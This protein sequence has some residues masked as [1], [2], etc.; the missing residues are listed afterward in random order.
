MTQL[1]A[2]VVT[3][4]VGSTEL[5]TRLGEDR[6]DDLR[7]AHDQVLS[8]A[9]IANGG[10]VVKG[11]GDGI[12]ARF[13]GAADA[14]TAAVAMQQAAART[15]LGHSEERLHIRIG[16]AVGDISLEEGDVFGT[17]VIE[18]SRLCS[19]AEGGQI[20]VADLVRV[21]T[22]GR[23]EHTFTPLGP[24]PLKGLAAPVDVCEVGWEALKSGLPNF[25]LPA[26]LTGSDPFGFAGRVAAR[27]QLAAR[28]KA[29]CV[30][31]RQIVLVAGEPGIGKTRL[32]SELARDVADDG[33]VVTLGRCFEDV[34]AA[35]APFGEALAHLVRHV[36]TALLEAHVSDVG[37]DLVRVVP[38]LARRVSLPPLTKADAE[39]ERM[40]LFDAV[41]DLLARVSEEAPVLL[42][43]DDL[44]W[45]DPSTVEMLLWLAR[46]SRPMRL[47]VVGTY[48]DTD[49]TRTHAFGGALTELRRTRGTER[50]ALTGLD[51]H[52][53]GAFLER[54]GGQALDHAAM[55]FAE[56]LYAETEGNPFFLQELLLHLAET[57]ALRKDGDRWVSSRPIREL[58]VPEGVRDLVGRRLSMLDEKVN[59]ALRAASVLGQEFD[60]G[61]LS[62]L[63]EASDDELLDLL[64]GPCRRGL[65]RELG[66]DTYRF[67]HA[68]IRQTLYE[69]LAAGR[70]ARLHRLAADALEARAAP[71]T[72][73]GHHLIEAGPR[74]DP[75]RAIA[76]SRRAAGQAEEQLA[77]EQAAAWYRRALDQA[78]LVDLDGAER[79]EILLGLGRAMNMAG[80]IAGARSLFVTAVEL[81][82]AAGATSTVVAA[83]L[84]YGS[85]AGPWLEYGDRIGLELLARAEALVADD[86]LAVKARIASRMAF[87]HLL[88]SDSAEGADLATLGT[89]LARRSGD[90]AALAEAIAYG[91][92]PRSALIPV[93]QLMPLAVEFAAVARTTGDASNI[94][95]GLM[96]RAEAHLR[97]GEVRAGGQML[98]E[99]ANHLRRIG[100]TSLGQVAGWHLSNIEL[101]CGRVDAVARH[102]EKAFARAI[103]AGEE[104]LAFGH[105]LIL[106]DVHDDDDAQRRLWEE[107][108]AAH[109]AIV[110]IFPWRAHIA[111]VQHDVETAVDGLREWR[112]TARPRCPSHIRSYTDAYAATIVRRL[113]D[114][115]LA[116]WL[117]GELAP[118]AGTWT[119]G[120]VP[121]GSYD[122]WLGT[123]ARISGGLDDARRH[124]HAARDAHCREGARFWLPVVY[125]EL[126]ELA[127]L[128]DD[129]DE[130]ERALGSAIELARRMGLARYEREAREVLRSR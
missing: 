7:R 17:P 127:L 71:P 4:L 12:L 85:S 22:H 69:E 89:E 70:R 95:S 108:A 42:V 50:V 88:D 60:I 10:E 94:A 75:V 31:E 6:A 21:L 104:L 98:L 97:A 44:H 99:W 79:A 25:P 77:W 129:R 26:A 38:E 59:D 124:L 61:V 121:F 35:F 65:L 101:M 105:R 120:G 36:D 56:L 78:E 2:I 92:W 111:A 76:L 37:G 74:G 9:V 72:E 90:A 67:A 106:A 81:A 41:V 46:A 86:D 13:N 40:R 15:F 45:A 103:S 91:V 118:H 114:R 23:G 68:L 125:T 54:A 84:A 14:V 51:E 8:E 63:T 48:R 62:H 29:A 119:F 115:E 24:R 28:W 32:A 3:D 123:L 5:R 1:S 47:A 55:E 43:L 122:I 126:A 57:R 11:L 30:E 39:L 110:F 128:E 73:V 64:E 27:E 34:N 93:E 52:E 49:V 53:V 102:V 20:L 83:A 87:W 130:A 16:V 112:E 109:S 80:D 113:G 58:G 19:E 100:H 116:S 33:G 117:Y 107:T 82:E 18:S 66:V 96:M